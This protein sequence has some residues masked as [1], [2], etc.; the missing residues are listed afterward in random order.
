MSAHRRRSGKKK[1]GFQ[2]RGGTSHG[3]WLGAPRP[4]GKPRGIS[5]EQAKELGRLCRQHRV[6]YNGNG[7]T[8]AQAAREIDRLRSR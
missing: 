3:D 7:M 2:A 5:N 6:P 1:L 4:A 8:A